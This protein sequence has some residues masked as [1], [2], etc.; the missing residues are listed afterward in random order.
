MLDNFV[1]ERKILKHNKQ[2][3]NHEIIS[4][5]KSFFKY[6]NNEEKA[7]L[8]KDFCHTNKL[9]FDDLMQI[10]HD[11]DNLQFINR[12]FE[13]LLFL[14]LITPCLIE[15]ST[16]A[17]ICFSRCL[18]LI[19]NGDTAL[20]EAAPQYQF[21]IPHYFSFKKN[22]EEFCERILHGAETIKCFRET[23]Y[24]PFNHIR[25]KS[26]SMG[27]STMHNKLLD[28]FQS[29]YIIAKRVLKNEDKNS[30]PL[31]QTLF[32]K[33][34]HYKRDPVHCDDDAYFSTIN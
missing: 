17:A 1:N 23:E 27:I 11:N 13:S 16:A 25:I 26:L 30:L 32:K 19:A 10:F 6:L 9:V 21:L 14:R 20:Q 24:K 2:L 28:I 8:V 31:L 3:S 18:Q 29:N 7:T 22:K 34:E 4:E 15:L 5:L 33:I 12:T